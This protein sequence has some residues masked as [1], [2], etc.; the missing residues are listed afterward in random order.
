MIINYPAV[1]LADAYVLIVCKPTLTCYLYL[2][3]SIPERDEAI[4]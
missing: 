2:L 3:A 4:V 1:W